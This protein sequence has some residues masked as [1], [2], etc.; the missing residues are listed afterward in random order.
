MIEVVRSGKEKTYFAHC[1]KCGTDM[2]YRYDD[3]KKKE[4]MDA[5]LLLL[6][7]PCMWR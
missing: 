7:L 4:K 6:Y 5:V 2:T 3:I 1:V